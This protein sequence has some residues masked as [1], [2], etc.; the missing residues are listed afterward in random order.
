MK[1]NFRFVGNQKLQVNDENVNGEYVKINGETFY[2]ISN[3]D[4]MDPFFMSIVSS[5]DHWMF[6]SS[7]G[8]L[9]AGRKNPDNALFP[10]Y[11]DDIIHTCHE[12]TGSKTI[13][14]IEV[15]E[16]EYLWEPF[17]DYYK[18]LYK[19]KRNLYKNVAGNKIIFEEDNLDL[20]LTFSYS[21][22]NSEHFGFVKKSKLINTSAKD[23]KINLLDGIQN[24]LSAGVYQQFQTEYSTLA[25]G[26]KKN[27]LLEEYGLGIYSLSSLPS[28]KAEP[29]ES[30]N[31]TV[32]W[33]TGIRV[34]KYL[35][36][37]LQLNNYRAGKELI[38]ESDIKGN[39]GS[40]FINCDFLLTHQKEWL[41]VSEINQDIT[42]IVELEELFKSEKNIQNIV[43]K[44]IN[45]GSA[46][47][48]KIIASADGN[49]L[50][51][52]KLVSS[53]HF[54]NVLFNTMRGGIFSHS[55]LIDINDFIKFVKQTNKL[56]SK[57][58]KKFLNKIESKILY[59]D[60]IE[61][62]KNQND[63]EFTKLVYEYLPL[64]FSRRHG[65]S[66]RPWNR[67]SINVKDDKG[68]KILDYEGNWRDIFQNWEA[69]T[70]SY[71]GYIESMIVKFL[72]ASTADG[73]NPYRV[74]R[75]G[76]D[77]EV[78]E[79][80]MPWANIGYWGDHQIIY[81]LKLLELSTKHNPSKLLSMIS[82]NI[83][84]YSNVPYKI[85]SYNELFDDPQN[86][87]GYD[88]ELHNEIISKEEEI[89]SDAKFLMSKEGCL[90]QTNLAEK[91][92]ITLLSKLSNFI[93]GG[94]IWMNTQRPEW[95]DANNALV[96]NGVSMVTLYY[97]RR[98][99][100]FC[101]NL[102]AKVE[103]NEILLSK[104][105]GELFNDI[106][107]VLHTHKN[108]LNDDITDKNRKTILDGL[109]SSGSNYRNK[110]YSN[111]FSSY[112][113]NLSIPG[114]IDF[115][116]LTNDYVDHTIKLN[117]RNDGLY[118][119]YNLMSVV[120]D[121][122][123][124]ITNLYEMLEGQ[125]AVLSSGIL[126]ADESLEVLLSLRKSQLYREDQ[127]SY[128][129]YPDRQL[130]MFVD[131]NII[132]DTDFNSL[133]LLKKLIQVENTDILK[134]DNQG[135]A[136]FSPEI[137]NAQVLKLKLEMLKSDGIIDFSQDEE[138]RVMEIYE[139]VF[140]HK[141]FTG[142]SGTFFKYEGLGS[143][144]WHMVSKL[145]LA[146]QETYFDAL[147][148]NE[149]ES[150]LL[151]LKDHYYKIQDGIGLTKSPEKYGAFPTDPYSHTPSFSGVQQ[152]GMT[153]QV[154]EDIISRYGELG[155]SIEEGKIIINP[156]LLDESEFL[157]QPEK[158]EYLDINGIQRSIDLKENSLAFTYCQ[159]PFIYI[160]SNN[161]K[162]VASKTN[163]DQIEF[164]KYVIPEELS[165]S[166]FYREGLLEKLEVYLRI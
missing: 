7:N 44:N 75:D 143:I 83:F 95:N 79:P 40:Y 105:A 13:I 54:S 45:D 118:H 109:G 113:Q 142:R 138:N 146:V 102:F 61:E 76:I 159:V 124:E 96:G 8:G 42:D 116:K 12:N 48:I 80:D 126:S 119:A 10:Y 84:T 66:S 163:G 35:L 18:Y 141:S 160:Q 140:N 108:L 24:I 98:Y 26:Y 64:T 23:V 127:D 147:S 63:N 86:T 114:L 155:I 151:R 101:L 74:T 20:G 70:F 69:L 52:N 15:D 92:L 111:S 56:I 29:S 85:K 30:L 154:K 4:K 39:R 77:W 93:P 28:D 165:R 157:F 34:V 67:F 27:E 89:G 60:L 131:K 150:I 161:N 32:V 162:I 50:T 90:Y 46:E 153:G 110:I 152:P 57:R 144:Y 82:E 81:L 125:V 17:S 137:R 103:T 78:P 11:T 99:V 132:S 120:N 128:L 72:N 121:E 55:Y 149:E 59:F 123:I 36:S 107:S 22:L 139:S 47:L 148:K 164:N 115:L 87:I 37:S 136:H 68:E 21:W 65:D 51:N 62:V 158:F 97:I 33:S 135:K 145:V 129:L 19:T 58:Q 117:K 38:N 104:E 14:L 53:R 100:T 134:K 16:T 88:F 71:P 73:Y 3:Y 1:K 112:K 130:P 25:D 43:E 49:Q 133:E 5:S 106:S 122:E 41:I 91:L 9:T 166:I 6:I 31:A 156:S 2:K 94:G